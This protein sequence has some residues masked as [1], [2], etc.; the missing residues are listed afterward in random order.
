MYKLVLCLR[1]LRTRWIALIPIISVMLGVATLIVVNAVM[2][3]FS[4]KLHE[5]LH[6]SLG[7]CIFESASLDG[8]SDATKHMQLIDEAAGDL[9]S[10]MS[11]TANVPAMLSFTC[12]GKRFNKQ[13]LLVGIDEGT[14]ADVSDFGEFMQHAANR[15]K[16]SFN[17][18]ENGYDTFDHQ[19]DDPAKLIPRRQMEYA[20]WGYRRR[21]A[22]LDKELANQNKSVIQTQQSIP[23]LDPFANAGQIEGVGETFDPALEQHTGIV[24][25]INIGRFRYSDDSEGFLVLPGDDVE[26][27]YPM[28]T[29]PPKPGS[30]FFTVVDFYESKF[31]ESD[32]TFAFVPLQKLQSLRGMIDPQ[33][34]IANFNT[35]QIR[36]KEGVSPDILRDRIQ[37]A[38]DPSLYV[39][40]TWRDKHGTL[41]SAVQLETVILNILLF[42]IIAVAGF[43]ILAIFFMIVVE[44]TRDIGILKSLGAGQFGVM[45]IFI[46]YG[47]ILG[48]IGSSIGMGCGLLIVEY[49]DQIA[50]MI[51]VFK[52][53]PVFDPSVYCFNKIPKIVEPLTVMLVVLGAILISVISS[54]LPAYRAAKMHPV[55]ALRWD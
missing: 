44:K 5:Q 1:Y 31:T 38:F 42:M 8:I 35:I 25:G 37:A 6:G 52:G 33:S 10:G 16:L 41:L 48:V 19:A 18:H 23:S 46:T 43:S 11:P 51:E 14:Y 26:V 2:Q 7:D 29:T 13:I 36:C 50:D 39:I 27:T 53:S 20:G 28:S 32:S 4:S 21:K 17:L 9:I 12:N 34:G 3:G 40:S 22:A 24:L 54:V 30:S 15:E 55:S 45:G 49:L 47:L